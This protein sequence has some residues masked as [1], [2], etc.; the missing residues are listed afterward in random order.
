MGTIGNDGQTQMH[1]D[2]CEVFHLAVIIR[3]F[4]SRFTEGIA[5]KY[6]SYV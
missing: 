4:F 2:P 3:L 5:S 1:A 6:N